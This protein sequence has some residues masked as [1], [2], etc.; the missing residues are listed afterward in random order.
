M[1][2]FQIGFVWRFLG[3]RHVVREALPDAIALSRLA[4]R[5]RTFAGQASH[6]VIRRILSDALRIVSRDRTGASASLCHRLAALP[7][8]AATRLHLALLIPH[9][10]FTPRHLE[11]T[12]RHLAF[13]ICHLAFVI[14]H[15]AFVICH[16]AFVI[17]HSSFVICHLAFVIC[18]LPFVI[19]HPAFVIW[20]LAF[21]I[22]HLPFGICHLSS[23]IWH[24]SSAIRHLS[25]AIRHLSF[26]I[27]HS[28]SAIWHSSSAICH[29][30]FGICHL[31][32]GIC[33]PA[34][35]ICHLAF[36]IC[37]LAFGICHLSFGIRHPA[38]VICHPA[39]AIRHPAFAI[40]HPAFAI[41]LFPIPHYKIRIPQFPKRF[42]RSY[43]LSVPGRLVPPVPLELRA[44]IECRAVGPIGVL[45]RRAGLVMGQ[46]LLEPADVPI[47]DCGEDRPRLVLVLGPGGDLVE[48]QLFPERGIAVRYPVQNGYPAFLGGSRLQHVPG[49][50]DGNNRPRP[51]AVVLS[52]PP[53]EGVFC[54]W[55]PPLGAWNRSGLSFLTPLSIGFSGDHESSAFLY[56]RR[57]SQ[58]WYRLRKKHA[59][60]LEAL[61]VT[62]PEAVDSVSIEEGRRF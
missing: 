53:P 50:D 19:C 40:R 47:D 10:Q 2:R 56:P 62:R 54:V 6:G 5:V 8:I 12:L 38:F 31:A 14:C 36:G 30:A 46:Q 26:V 27:C 16:P 17:C 60:S 28:S 1:L 41:R 22:W 4:C 45:C 61:R 9:L 18:H 13:V 43:Q 44:A 52:S 34:F 51:K 15:L 55:L 42:Q 29:L 33:H 39:F 37:H 20:H 11:L 23:A 48:V 7:F 32:F 49:H 35:V 58:S 59:G 21:G 24:L 57:P 3:R 25:S